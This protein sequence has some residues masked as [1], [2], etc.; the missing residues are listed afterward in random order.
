MLRKLHPSSSKQAE[1]AWGAAITTADYGSS[2]FGSIV[3]TGSII[4]KST[5]AALHKLIAIL[6]Q[7][8]SHT[9]WKRPICGSFSISPARATAK[10]MNRSVMYKVPNKATDDA[11]RAFICFGGLNDLLLYCTKLT[12]NAHQT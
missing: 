2:L 8:P 11:I 10:E 5:Q 1:H 7:A 9:A 12:P 4:N 3:C 6:W